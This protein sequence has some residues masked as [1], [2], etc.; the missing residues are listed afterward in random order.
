M[1]KKIQTSMTGSLP[2]IPR[3][4]GYH[5]CQGNG[6]I[7]TIIH[8]NIEVDIGFG[9]LLHSTP[10]NYDHNLLSDLEEL[11]NL[12]EDYKGDKEMLVVLITMVSDYFIKYKT[13][14]TFEFE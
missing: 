8:C 10:I 3:C 1:I 7:K 13:I 6:G 4:V 11:L 2:I 9:Q 14:I 5:H 12:L